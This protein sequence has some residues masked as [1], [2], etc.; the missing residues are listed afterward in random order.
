MIPAFTIFQK[1][2]KETL[3][4]RRTLIIMIG[5]PLLLIPLILS[6][7]SKVASS[8]AEAEREKDVRIGLVSNDN[9]EELIE[10]L[11]RRQ[12]VLVFEDI[13]PKDFKKFIREDSLDLG[14]VFDSGF[15]AAIESGK[16]GTLEVF[17]NS[18]NEIP[19][20]R[21]KTTIDNYH[22]EIRD[23]RLAKLNATPQL[24]EP[25]SVEMIDAYTQRENFGKMVGG[26]LP[27]IFVLFCLMGAMYPSIDLFT[28]EKERSTLETIL[29]VPASRIQILSGKMMAIVLAGVLSGGL[30]ILG[31]YLAIK[32]NPEVPDMIQNIILQILNPTA[33]LQILLLI[34]PLTI[35]FAGILIPASIYARNFK[36]AQSIIQPML[37][38]VIIPLAI[39]ATLPNLDLTFATAMIPIVNVGLASRDIVAGTMNPAMFVVVFASLVVLAGVGIG[40]CVRWFGQEGNLLRI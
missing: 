4:D 7:A 33:I 19:F 17:H 31:M 39:V 27:Y 21:V 10:R 40:L 32:F 28:G 29:T 13:P 5:M 1:E 20:N 6:V 35:F 25:T 14:L 15:D 23:D 37:I 16:T 24:V 30:A 34:I 26:F 22:T 8:Q 2:I 38:V 18:T 11:K 36:E 3:R 12:D 9:G